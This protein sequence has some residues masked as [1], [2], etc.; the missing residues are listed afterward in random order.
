MMCEIKSI[1][2]MDFNLKGFH[3]YKN[4]TTAK[5]DPR[6]KTRGLINISKNKPKDNSKKL[7]K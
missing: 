4:P 6:K 1:I 2:G 5:I 7:N 3:E